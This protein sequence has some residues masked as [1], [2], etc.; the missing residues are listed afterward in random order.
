M[1]GEG[2]EREQIIR[3][4]EE[5]RLGSRLYAAGFVQSVAPFMRAADIVVVPSLLDGMPLVILEAQ[6]YEK[7]VV[8]SAVGAFPP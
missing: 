8:A 6:A 3:M 5:Y 2:P 4:R 7:P 1:T